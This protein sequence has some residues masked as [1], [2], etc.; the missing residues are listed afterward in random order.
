MGPHN[1]TTD[2]PLCSCGGMANACGDGT[3]MA[4]P[5]L[6]TRPPAGLVLLLLPPPLLYLLPPLVLVAPPLVAAPKPE[7]V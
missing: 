2:P 6:A 5:L 4:P 1:Y 3:G 7:L